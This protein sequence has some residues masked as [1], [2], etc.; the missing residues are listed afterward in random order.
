MRGVFS[1][2]LRRLLQTW[3]VFSAATTSKSSIFRCCLLLSYRREFALS[4][5][6]FY[7]AVGITDLFRKAMLLSTRRLSELSLNRL[8][9]RFSR[10]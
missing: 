9:T 6:L 3:V 4:P 7:L 8:D 5:V 1:S 2:N 10:I